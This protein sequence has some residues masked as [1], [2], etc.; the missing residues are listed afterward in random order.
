MILSAGMDGIHHHIEFV[1]H[2]T[3]QM[4]IITVVCITCVSLV[5]KLCSVHVL[6]LCRKCEKMFV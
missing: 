2:H 3:R 1:V 5:Q 6:C 4:I